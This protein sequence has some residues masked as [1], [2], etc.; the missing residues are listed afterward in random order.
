FFG[1]G[2]TEAG[3]VDSC[4][5]HVRATH[6]SFASR[7][8]RLGFDVAVG[9]SGTIGA[10]C[11]MA[12]ARREQA[13]PRTWNNFELSRQDL[14]AVVKSLVKAPTVAARAKLPGLE[15]RRADIILAGALI[16]EQVFEEFGI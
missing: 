9:S 12:A 5:R 11:A 8:R 15:P 1:D 13:P 2:R 3:A 4:R 16:L 14:D 7:V 10:L 6:A